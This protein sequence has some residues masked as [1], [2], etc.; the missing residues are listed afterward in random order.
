MICPA[1]TCDVEG[2]AVVH[3]RAEEREPHGHVHPAL[4][5]H[6]LYGDVSL[7]V[8]LHH[9]HIEL[10]LSGAGKDRVGRVGA[11]DVYARLS[12]PRA[13]SSLRWLSW[14]RP[15]RS[16]RARLARGG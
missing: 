8:V 10:P 6:Q 11:A 13:G 3:A 1:G 14:A 4:E 9:H 15:P 2:G 12:R 7:V 5:A 16:L